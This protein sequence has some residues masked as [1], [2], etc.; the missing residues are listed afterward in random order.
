M[1]RSAFTGR[2]VKVAVL[3]TGFDLN[4]PDFAGRPIVSSSFITG[5]PVQD[6]NGHGTHCIGAAMGPK[7]PVGTHRR[8][9][10]AGEASIFA[11]K[12][13]SNAGSGADGGILAGIDWAIRNGCR[14]ISKKGMVAT[15]IPVD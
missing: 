13:L 6:G 9:G 3:D 2:D 8:Y 1:D 11:G 5:E 4:H 15:T 14:A 12:V 7:T 10:V